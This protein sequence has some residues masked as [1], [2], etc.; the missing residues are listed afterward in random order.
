[1]SDY[2]KIVTIFTSGSRFV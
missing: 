1:M 2:T